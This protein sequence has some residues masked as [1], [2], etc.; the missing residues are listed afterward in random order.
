ME[1]AHI[2]NIAVG[3]LTASIAAIGLPLAL[4]KRKKQAPKKSGEL[5]SHLQNMGLDLFLPEEET[6]RGKIGIQRFTSSKSQ[7]LIGIR[8]KNIEWINLIGVSTQY[9]TS[10]FLDFQISSPNLEIRKPKKVF[11]KMK[12]SRENKDAVI[13]W[14]GDESF[15]MTLSLDFNLEELMKKSEFKGILEI[16]PEPKHGCTRIRIPYVLP[17]PELTEAINIIAGHVKSEF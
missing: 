13:S 11:L 2:I 10:Y 14:K 9:G 1:W 12:R 15:S 4:S 5:Y 8:G 7:G 16:A 17:S 3:I 6:G